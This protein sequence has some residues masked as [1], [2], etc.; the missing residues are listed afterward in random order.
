MTKVAT[1]NLTSYDFFKAAAVLLMICDHIGFYFYPD[2]AHHPEYNWFRV[3]GRMCVPIWFFLVGYA[4]SRDLS[5]KIWFGMAILE[6]GSMVAGLSILPI[7][8]LGTMIAIR[9]VLDPVMR[10]ATKNIEE[11][12]KVSLF[13]IIMIVPTA[14]VTEYGT[15]GLLIAMFGWM[16]R[17]RPVYE[18]VKNPHTIYWSFGLFTVAHFVVFQEHIFGF[19]VAEKFAL[20]AGIMLVIALL[21]RFEPRE[22]PDLTKRMP[23]AATAAIQFLGR[24]TMEIYIGHLLLFKILGLALEP[25]R[26]HLLRWSLF[27]MPH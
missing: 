3:F 11:L 12:L 18:A 27:W 16:M 8:V 26:F 13:M 15:Q 20:L 4:Q 10:I 14:T 6:A 7:N 22:Y 23:G 25:N 1:R 17:H 24:W 5:P 19:P 21:Y 9:L 2:V